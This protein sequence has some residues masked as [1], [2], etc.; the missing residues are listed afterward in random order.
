M[1]V[2]L[3]FTIDPKVNLMLKISGL[4]SFILCL[5]MPI[6]ASKGGG[7]EFV[8]SMN[9]DLVTEGKKTEVR[10]LN[11]QIVQEGLENNI[12]TPVNSAI[13]NVIEEM[14]SGKRPRRALNKEEVKE[15]FPF[16]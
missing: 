12:P 14:E 2:K 15:L 16:L 4:P 9:K 1:S 5:L 3:N 11:G 7:R 6:L 8:M 10:E 13:V